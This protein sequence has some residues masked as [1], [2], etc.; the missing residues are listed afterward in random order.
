V[1]PIASVIVVA[2]VAL[3]VSFSAVRAAAIRPGLAL[4]ST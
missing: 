1:P 2:F 4:R 3:A